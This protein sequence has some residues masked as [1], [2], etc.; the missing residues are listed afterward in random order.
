MGSAPLFDHDATSDDPGVGFSPSA[1]HGSPNEVGMVELF[2]SI[3]RADVK[4]L[5]NNVKRKRGKERMQ[6][7]HADHQIAG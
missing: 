1:G 6:Y 7:D 2:A 3:R 5:H 4:R